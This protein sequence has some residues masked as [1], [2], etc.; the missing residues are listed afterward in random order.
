MTRGEIWWA[1]FGLPF[2]SEPGFERPVF[3]VQADAFNASRIATTIVV[4]FTT[5]LQLA[6]APGNVLADTDDTGL[7]RTSVIVVSQLAA[8]DKRRLVRRHGVLSYELVREV[9]AGLELV[10]SLRP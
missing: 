3:V 5:N 7:R 1:D 10:L 4:P 2:G 6:D 8:V 9:D